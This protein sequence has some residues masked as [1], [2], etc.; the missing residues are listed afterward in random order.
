MGCLFRKNPRTCT[1][2]GAP[3]TCIKVSMFSMVPSASSEH[4]GYYNNSQRNLFY[5]GLHLECPPGSISNPREQ[6]W[7]HHSPLQWPRQPGGN[8]SLFEE[9]DCL[10]ISNHFSGKSTT[11]IMET[12][13]SLSPALSLGLTLLTR[14]L[15]TNPRQT[16][17]PYGVLILNAPRMNGTSTRAKFLLLVPISAL[18]SS[19]PRF[20][21][22]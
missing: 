12:S 19:H 20:F 2:R 15:P 4:Y 14:A 8:V 11:L 6:R 7:C 16:P 3:W 9:F 17:E 10:L 5:R 1:D 18:R 21:H 22:L 13:S